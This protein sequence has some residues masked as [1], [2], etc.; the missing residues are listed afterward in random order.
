M[1]VKDAFK[2]LMGGLAII[3]VT[4]LAVKLSVFGAC[5]KANANQL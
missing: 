2:L 5:C 4:N 1:I 3:F